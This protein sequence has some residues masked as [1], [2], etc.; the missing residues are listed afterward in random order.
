[1]GTHS[2]VSTYETLRKRVRETLLIGQ[3]KIEQEKIRTYWETGKLIN[4]FIL[5]GKEYAERGS[6]VIL[7]LSKDLDISERSLYETVQFAKAF[8]KVSARA[9]SSL[10]WSHLRKLATIPDPER[11]NQLVKQAETNGWSSNELSFRLTKI[12]AIEFNNSN[13]AANH[14]PLVTPTLGSF[15]TYEIKDSESI[16]VAR[17]LSPSCGS[18]LDFRF[19]WKQKGLNHEN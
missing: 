5:K 8:P 7:K 6:E 19:F 1:M 4:D 13:S 9:L 16:H 18:I 11:R 12:K 3:A 10:T 15:W 14:K 2:L 17:G